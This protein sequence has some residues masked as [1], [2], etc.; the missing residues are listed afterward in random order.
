MKN[1]LLFGVLIGFLFFTL[2]DQGEKTPPLI[3][4]SVII[5][6]NHEKYHIHHWI[7]FSILFL[8]MIP[9]IFKYKYKKKSSFILGVCLG[10]IIQGLT[11]SDAFQIK[12]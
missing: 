2:I 8:V 7:I 3:F 9:I 5:S 1:Y 4:S 12:L 10:S 6:I 11:Y